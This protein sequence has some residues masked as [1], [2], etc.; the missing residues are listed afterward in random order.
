MD[1]AEDRPYPPL[2]D[3][4]VFV[5]GATATGKSRIAMRLARQV[6]GEILSLDSIAVY[7]GMDIGTAKPDADD[8]AALPH[9]LIDQ[10]DPDD[11][12]SVARYL[13]AA[14]RVVDAVLDRGGVPIFVGGTPMFLKGVLRGFDPGPPADWDFRRQVEEDLARHGVDALRNRLWQVDPLSAS[15]IDA[16]DSRRMIRAL[17]VAKL[18]GQPL[19]HRQQQFDTVRDA[20]QCAALVVRR[21]RAEIHQRINARV[22]AMFDAGWVAE[23]RRLAQRFPTLSRTAASAVG[24]R[25]ILQWAEEENLSADDPDAWPRRPPEE[26]VQQIAARTR[27]MARRQ[28]TWFRSFTE[29]TDL[30]GRQIDDDDQAQQWVDRVADRISGGP[31]FQ[32]GQDKPD[33]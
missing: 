7:R 25:E 10:V 9:H 29:L 6:G 11:D 17:E 19:S 12:Y 32:L 14:H 26:I 22:D 20:D 21:D 30:P 31:P 27:Q 8:Q 1:A 2:I 23:V 5:T 18:T 13:D 3:R 16:N 4:A 33:R 24:Y 15:R 28:E